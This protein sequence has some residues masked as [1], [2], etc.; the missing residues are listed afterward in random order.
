[1]TRRLPE[2]AEDDVVRIRRPNLGDAP[3]VYRAVDS[4]RP[5]LECWMNWCTPG[6]SLGDAE[7][8]IMRSAIG[9]PR[10][11]ECPFVIERVSDGV[12]VGCTGVHGV[13]DFDAN[14]ELG[15]W[16]RSDETGQGYARR[17]AALA[18]G[19]AFE[20]LDAGRIGILVA[21]ENAPSLKV[22]EAVGAVREGVLRERML[23]R[24]ERLDAVMFGLL[25]GE[26]A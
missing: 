3:A 4:S 9:W 16:I 26:V 5:E 25:P 7:A 10:G 2:Q 17:A 20:H 11:A 18:A 14:Y 22:A 15:Y 12:I 1:M 13:G 23:V 6:Y 8:W 24:G 19:Y 21:T